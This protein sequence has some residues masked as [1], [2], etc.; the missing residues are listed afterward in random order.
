MTTIHTNIDINWVKD[1]TLITP[2]QREMKWTCFHLLHLTNI[3]IPSDCHVQW[4]V[5]FNIVI[6]TE[7]TILA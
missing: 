5:F 3:K 2:D 1:E 7:T 4:L 6:L